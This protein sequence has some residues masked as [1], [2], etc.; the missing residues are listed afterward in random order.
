[1]IANR[2][3][4][5]CSARA[6]DNDGSPR[7]GA[8]SSEPGDLEPYPS[9]PAAINGARRCLTGCRIRKLV[10]CLVHRRFASGHTPKIIGRLIAKMDNAIIPS[11]RSPFDGSSGSCRGIWH[12]V[13]GAMISDSAPDDVLDRGTMRSDDH[14]RLDAYD[15]GR[16]SRGR[17]QPVEIGH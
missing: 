1:M 7:S 13:R 6:I 3:A 12:K 17:C 16:L 2:G 8:G 5:D 11:A 10:D 15:H 9:V 14:D 4:D